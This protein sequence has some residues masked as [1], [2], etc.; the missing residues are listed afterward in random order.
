[1]PALR[2]IR[3]A[4]IIG[5]TSIKAQVP[6]TPVKSETE[7]RRKLFSETSLNDPEQSAGLSKRA[8]L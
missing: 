3:L 5:T 7:H 4:L 1:M 6:D 2:I 8:A